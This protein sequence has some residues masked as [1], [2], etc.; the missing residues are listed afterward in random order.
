MSWRYH[1]ALL[2]TA[3]ASLIPELELSAPQRSYGPN[4]LIW[5]LAHS[6]HC[7]RGRGLGESLA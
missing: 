1:K 2:R 7:P 3:A 4:A 5:L 6:G